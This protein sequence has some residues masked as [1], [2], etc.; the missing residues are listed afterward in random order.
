MGLGM[1]DGCTLVARFV[2]SSEV[3][4]TEELAS[5][6]FVNVGLGTGR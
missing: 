2:T 5:G 3:F 6:Y 1:I 4:G